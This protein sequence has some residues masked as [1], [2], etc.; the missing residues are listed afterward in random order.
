MPLRGRFL[1]PPIAGSAEHVIVKRGAFR[2]PH[3]KHW[4]GKLYVF[5]FVNLRNQLSVQQNIGSILSLVTL[6][7]HCIPHLDLER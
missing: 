7:F 3:T 6:V 5:T 4:S 2:L 1:E